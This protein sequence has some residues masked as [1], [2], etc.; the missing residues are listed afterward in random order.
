MAAGLAVA[1]VA[2]T[3]FRVCAQ[4]LPELPEVE[5]VPLSMSVS[6]YDIDGRRYRDAL[7][8]MEFAGPIGYEAETR[9]FFSYYFETAQSAD[10]CG[11][12]YL[13]LPLTV[14]ILYPNWTGYDRARRSEREAWDN[15]M[16]VL[17]VHEN[18][19]A[20]IAFLGTVETYNDVVQI[21]MQ[22]DC[23]ELETRVREMTERANNRLQTWQR[24]YDAVTEHGVE[25]HGFDLQ[26]F[27]SER[28]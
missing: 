14:E 21:G 4:G 3:T 8:A 22:P 12:R 20:V 24:E 13:E 19:H 25:Q 17:T 15:R 10:G 23:D 1:L 6:Y 7:E 16:H 2:G 5:Q 18:V 9:T 28:L 27:M 11:L 26:T